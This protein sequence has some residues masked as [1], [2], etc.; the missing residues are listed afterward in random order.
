MGSDHLIHSATE[1]S[2]ERL[3]KIPVYILPPKVPPNVTRVL[4]TDAMPACSAVAVPLPIGCFLLKGLAMF[5]F[6]TEIAE[7]ACPC[8]RKVAR[9]S[10]EGALTVR[11]EF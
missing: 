3:R 1:A 11:N 2:D 4:T 8:I 5:V 9:L 10:L 6:L 7:Q